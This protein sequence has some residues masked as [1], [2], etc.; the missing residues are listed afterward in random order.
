M[1]IDYSFMSVYIVYVVLYIVFF[2]H[3]VYKTRKKNSIIYKHLLFFNTAFTFC[4]YNADIMNLVSRQR[5]QNDHFFHNSPGAERF[6]GTPH[7]MGSF[8]SRNQ[9]R[10][11]YC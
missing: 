10:P 3:F 8:F 2:V 11:E 4:S 6:P 5:I 7:F 9:D 1:L